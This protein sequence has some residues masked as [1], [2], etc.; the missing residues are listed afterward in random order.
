MCLEG[1]HAKSLTG[2]WAQTF[3]LQGLTTQGSTTFVDFNPFRVEDG[4]ERKDAE[5]KLRAH[6]G[7]G[8][9]A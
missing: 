1:S 8:L 3:Q 6:G 4:N 9:L 5:Y 2:S 7:A